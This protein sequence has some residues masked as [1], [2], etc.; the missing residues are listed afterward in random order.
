MSEQVDF[1][2]DKKQLGKMSEIG[3]EARISKNTEMNRKFN[4]NPPQ[5]FSCEYCENLKN[6]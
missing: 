2:R 6:I 5:V 3:N 1:H 4:P